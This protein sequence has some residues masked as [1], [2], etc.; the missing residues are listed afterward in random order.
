MAEILK[1]PVTADA[2]QR[3]TDRTPTPVDNVLRNVALQSPLAVACVAVLPNGEYRVYASLGRAIEA[4][5]MLERGKDL[6]ALIGND[7]ILDAAR[8]ADRGEG[9]T[10]G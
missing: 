10:N 3:E 9:N 5:H 1:L 6:I 7:E 2:E 8:S 4:S